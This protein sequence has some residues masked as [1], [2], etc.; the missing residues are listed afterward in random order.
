[1]PVTYL[2]MIT[3]HT[4]E[5]LPVEFA[6]ETSG[7]SE[8]EEFGA[9]KRLVYIGSLEELEKLAHPVQPPPE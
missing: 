6:P 2:P 5:V 9:G 8:P 3:V 7:V 4:N 1:M